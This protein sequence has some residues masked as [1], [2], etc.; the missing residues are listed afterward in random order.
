[1]VWTIELS[2]AC[3]EFH[4]LIEVGMKCGMNFLIICL[5]FSI[6]QTTNA[7]GDASKVCLH[8]ISAYAIGFVTES[9]VL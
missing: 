4:T 8:C 1:M 5:S 6:N 7:A 9:G 2:G 3:L